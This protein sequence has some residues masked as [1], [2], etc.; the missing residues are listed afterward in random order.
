MNAYA[1]TNNA[2]TQ[3]IT[4]IIRDAKNDLRAGLWSGDEA[5]NWVGAALVEALSFMSPDSRKAFITSLESE[6]LPCFGVVP[7]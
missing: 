1:T 6:D 5:L 4:K 2:S 7:C 3:P